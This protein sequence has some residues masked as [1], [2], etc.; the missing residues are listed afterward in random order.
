M[1]LAEHLRQVQP[2][3]SFTNLAV[4]GYRARDAIQRELP[5]AIALQPDLITVF[6]GGNDV[7]LTPRLDGARFADELDQLLAPFADPSVTVVLSTLPDLAAVSPLPPPLRGQ[8]RRRVET[9]NEVIRQAAHRYDTVLLDAWA[10]PRILRNAMWSFDRIHPSAAGHRLIAAS[11]AELLGVPASAQADE[12]ISA[13][14]S[15]LIRRYTVE[16]AW[17]LRHGLERSPAHG[18]VCWKV[19]ELRN[20]AAS[21]ARRACR[22]SGRDSSGRESSRNPRRPPPRKPS[23]ASLR[24]P[25][26]SRSALRSMMQLSYCGCLLT[27]IRS[28]RGGDAGIEPMIDRLVVLA[29]MLRRAGI[30]VSTGDVVDAGRALSLLDLSDRELLR[31]GL[32]AV[33]VKHETDLAAFDR[34]FDVVFSITPPSGTGPARGGRIGGTR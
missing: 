1:L 20:P 30:D 8:L 17:L 6:I 4:R 13:S 10:E 29:G 14:P 19:E 11:V 7:L 26:P 28:R 27:R 34:V 18:V 9:V 12:D 22:R 15:D 33:L 32:R 31:V 5:E 2:E 25:G 3:M 21:C 23:R 24:S 16:M